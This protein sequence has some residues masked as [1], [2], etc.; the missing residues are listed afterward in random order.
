MTNEERIRVLVDPANPH[1]FAVGELEELGRRIVASADGVEAVAVFREE[2]GYGGGL[3]E[4]LDL[5]FEVSGGVVST[6]IVGKT[7]Y[8]TLGWLHERW[9]NDRAENANPRP[10]SLTVYDQEGRVVRQV[11]IDLP[12]G[13]LVDQDPGTQYIGHPRPRLDRK[14]D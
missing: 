9:K 12:A 6:A 11:M 4:A 14:V 10:R 1:D 5:W 7:I 8:T 2:E 3:W 13:E